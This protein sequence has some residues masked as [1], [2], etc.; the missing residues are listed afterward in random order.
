MKESLEALQR[1]CDIIKAK[2]TKEK[3]RKDTMPSAKTLTEPPS[4]RLSPV[5]FNLN[6]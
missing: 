4:P 2:L 3:Q 6:R 5:S 1:T